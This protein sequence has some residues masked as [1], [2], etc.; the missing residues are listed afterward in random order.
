MNKQ[1]ISEFLGKEFPDAI[2]MV[3]TVKP[4]KVKLF[5][6]GLDKSF[7]LFG[8]TD[9]DKMTH[10]KATVGGRLADVRANFNRHMRA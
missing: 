7:K 8:E 10:L 3:K 1:T 6:G 2:F 5:M 9:E 4:A